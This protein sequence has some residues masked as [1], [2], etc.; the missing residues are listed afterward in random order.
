MVNHKSDMLL[1]EKAAR[2]LVSVDLTDVSAEDI[3]V[4]LESVTAEPFSGEKIQRILGKAGLGRL[5]ATARD[6][7]GNLNRNGDAGRRNYRL[8]CEQLEKRMGPQPVH[9]SLGRP[10]V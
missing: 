9:R 7:R 8:D 3:D 4:F 1:A 2:V 6:C 10:G 5:R